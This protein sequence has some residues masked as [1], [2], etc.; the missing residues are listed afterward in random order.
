MKASKISSID[1]NQIHRI[2]VRR[3]SNPL[4]VKNRVIPMGETRMG[5]YGRK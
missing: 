4:E 1:G 5:L 2:S 3:T